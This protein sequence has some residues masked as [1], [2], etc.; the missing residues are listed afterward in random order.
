M[1]ACVDLSVVIRLN[2][3]KDN[4]ALSHAHIFSLQTPPFP[5]IHSETCLSLDYTSLVQF[6]VKLACL[7]TKDSVANETTLRK[8]TLSLGYELHRMNLA[9][10]GRDVKYTQ[11]LLIFDVLTT[12]SG[13]LAAISSVTLTDG[14]CPYKGIILIKSAK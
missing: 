14:T 1:A 4:T 7:S 3:G 6:T 9:V 8:S 2:I 13:M 10:A 5:A 12:R 11:C